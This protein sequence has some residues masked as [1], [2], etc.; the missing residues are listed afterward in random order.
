MLTSAD[1]ALN[2]GFRLA[3]RVEASEV[4]LLWYGDYWDGPIDGLLSFRGEQCWFELV[5]ENEGDLGEWYRRFVILRLTPERLAEEA[6]WHDLFRKHV[7]THADYDENGRAMRGELRPRDE[8][9]KF[10]EPFQRRIPRAF[11]DN[12]VLGWFER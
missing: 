4:R 10:Y 8:W 5:T 12:E 3:E 7:G 1:A 9:H 11:S 6:R 2:D